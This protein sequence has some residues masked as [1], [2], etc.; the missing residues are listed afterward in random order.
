L[1]VLAIIGAVVLATV[2]I[3]IVGFRQLASGASP[4]QGPPTRSVDAASDSWARLLSLSTDLGP[5]RVIS[6]EV[7]VTLASAQRPVVLEDW[8]RNHRLAVTWSTGERFAVVSGSSAS[9]GSAFGAPV[10]SYRSRSGE[11][12][13]SAIRQPGGPGSPASAASTTTAGC[14]RS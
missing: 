2:P 13:Y 4:P 8:A 10:D 1:R 12:F 3:G 7:L 6:I 11:A 14:R 5:A 9:V